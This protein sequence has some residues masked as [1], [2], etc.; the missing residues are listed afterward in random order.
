MVDEDAMF[1]ALSKNKA[2]VEIAPKTGKILD[3][4]ERNAPPINRDSG[5]SIA[6]HSIVQGDVITIGDL[7]TKKLT[8]LKGTL[9]AAIANKK[10]VNIHVNS[11]EPEEI[12]KGTYV[13]GTLSKQGYSCNAQILRDRDEIDWTCD[14]PE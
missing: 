8:S 3:F 2:Q 13:A 11:K 10:L 1:Q 14:P 7:K 4:T 12:L 6:R 5:K 9:S